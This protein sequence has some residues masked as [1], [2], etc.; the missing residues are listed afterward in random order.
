MLR[1]INQTQLFYEEE[2]YLAFLERLERFKDD[3]N[4]GLMAYS[5]MGNHIHLLIREDEAKISLIIKKIT[6]SYSHWFNGKYDRS[7]YLFQGRFRSEP[8]EDD[9]Y[10]LTVLRYIHN[11][12]VEVGKATNYSTSYDAYLDGSILVDTDLAL[13]MFSNNLKKARILFREFIADYPEK[14]PGVHLTNGREHVS[15]SDAIEIIKRIGEIS[16]CNKLVGFDK[17]QRNQVLASLKNAGLSIRQIA[18]LTGINRGVVQKAR[19]Q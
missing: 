17:K 14:E 7:G 1:G 18:R 10:F 15:D 3:C 8:V 5:L 9:A 2:D 13:A 4:F 19:E 12:P 6:L 16:S 11:N